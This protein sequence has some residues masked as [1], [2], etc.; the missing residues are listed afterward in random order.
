[1]ET[2]QIFTEQLLSEIFRKDWMDD[3]D[4]NDMMSAIK[5]QGL[6]SQLEN[7]LEVGVR[8]GYSVEQQIE[9]AKLMYK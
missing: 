5:Q 4:W 1:M 8:N 2:K 7:S 9:I 3:N 6:I